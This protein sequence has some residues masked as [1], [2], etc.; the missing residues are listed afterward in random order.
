MPSYSND[1]SQIDAVKAFVVGELA[2]WPDG[3][4]ASV[5][6]SGHADSYSRNVTLTLKA[7]LLVEDADTEPD[8]E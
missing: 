3:K 4:A 1:A 7:I 6:A 2:G 5:E 8:S